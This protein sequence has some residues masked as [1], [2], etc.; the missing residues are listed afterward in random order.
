MK[1]AT[2]KSDRLLRNES[3]IGRIYGRLTIKSFFMDNGLR[4]LC[5]CSCGLSK[6]ILAKSIRSGRTRSCGCFAIES[7]KSRKMSRTHGMRY[8]RT[9]NIWTMMKT[10]C[11][12]V[13]ATGYENYG[14]RG[15][16]YCSSWAKFENFFADMGEAPE[17][18]S[19]DRINNSGDYSK[20]N[21]KWSTSKEQANNRRKPSRISVRDSN[22][23]FTNKTIPN[24]ELLQNHR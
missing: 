1:I 4:F 23:K 20:E 18:M 12:N 10:R 3:E 19:I 13:N 15:I 7:L 16:S 21:C 22:G 9:Y 11:D 5:L 24:P 2:K 8:T 17:K 6:V 14:G